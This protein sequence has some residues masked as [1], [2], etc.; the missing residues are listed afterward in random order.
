[1]KNA[2]KIC[3]SILL[4]IAMLSLAYAATP[5]PELIG[6][7]GGGFEIDSL[8]SGN[9]ILTTVECG[10]VR[11]S[12]DGGDTWND[13]SKGIPVLG[14]EIQNLWKDPF[15]DNTIFIGKASSIL[16]STDNGDTWVVVKSISGRPFADF[17]AKDSMHYFAVEGQRRNMFGDPVPD[18][19]SGSR[20]RIWKSSDGGITWIEGAQVSLNSTDELPSIYIHPTTKELY[21]A[22]AS[23]GVRKS[24]NDGATWENYSE[25]LS[26]L[27][28]HRLVADPTNPNIMYLTLG[29]SGSNPS[30][31]Y[32]RDITLGNWENITYNLPS[33][34]DL[35]DMAV[36]SNGVLY[37]ANFEPLNGDGGVYRFEGN[38]WTHLTR[39]TENMEQGWVGEADWARKPTGAAITIDPNND[40][41]IHFTTPLRDQ[42]F[43]TINGGENWSQI[44]A[45]KNPD[46]TWSNR[47]MALVGTHT[48][49]VDPSNS[50]H[51]ILGYGDYGDAYSE[52]GGLTWRRIMSTAGGDVNKILFD[53]A[54]SSNVWHVA[55]YRGVP[56]SKFGIYYSNDSGK[57]MVIVGGTNWSF[58]NLPGGYIYDIALDLSSPVNNRIVYIVAEGKGVYKGQGITQKI[59]TDK[60]VK[61]DGPGL[62]VSSAA[63]WPLRTVAYDS[64]RGIL[65]VGFEIKGTGTGGVYKTTNGGIS[66]EEVTGLNGSGKP[67]R[68]SIFRGMYV[69]PNT[70]DLYVGT[71]NPKG[72]AYRLQYLSSSWDNL[73]NDSKIQGLFLLPG[74]TRDKDVVFISGETN[75]QLAKWDK[76]GLTNLM[77][78]LPEKVFP[79]GLGVTYDSATDTLYTGR[80][81]AGVYKIEDVNPESPDTQNPT[82]SITSPNNGQTVSGIIN[83]QATASDNV[84]VTKVEFYIEGIIKSTDFSS[85]YEYSW[86]TTEVA[87]GNHSILVKAYDATNNTGTASILA[88]VQN[89]Y[90]PP[91]N[92]SQNR[93][94]SPIIITPIIVNGPN[95]TVRMQVEY[96]ESSV[97]KNFIFPKPAF[98]GM[99]NF[100]INESGTIKTPI[101]LGTELQWTADTSKTAFLLFEIPSPQTTLDEVVTDD[102]TTYQKEINI[103]TENSLEGVS[104]ST[105]VDVSY[106]Y[107]KLYEWQ[108][109]WGDVTT[110]YNLQIEDGI[111][112]FSGF[113]LSDKQFMLEGTVSSPTPPPPGGGSGDGGSGG[114]GGGV[115]IIPPENQTEETP[116]TDIGPNITIITEDGTP[117][118]IVSQDNKTFIVEGKNTKEFEEVKKS[119]KLLFYLLAVAGFIGIL[120]SLYA[121]RVIQRHRKQQQKLAMAPEVN[122]LVLEYIKNMRMRKYSDEVIKSELIKV[123]WNKEVVE[124]AFERI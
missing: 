34:A 103:S 9:R 91:T 60:W 43:K 14:G 71:G 76:N 58:N 111:A 1:M 41:I 105:S 56:A 104:V 83:I 106:T 93:F 94:H 52:D 21:V 29:A 113:D 16:R 69:N 19:T 100:R 72:G 73:A 64:V 75:T 92:Q 78:R 89:E 61:I 45:I 35:F 47:G 17:A 115:V 13:S 66:W 32:R 118:P 98:V 54:N 96:N 102:G 86:N 123:G 42:H 90:V 37:V 5:P 20:A 109:D 31:V 82:A 81:C 85:P 48:I 120:V 80:T 3:M 124:K 62:P 24:T 55:G 59:D 15:R 108:P 10:G 23:G 4:S 63:N 11:V 36:N 57:N 70:G 117:L 26:H 88:N 46:G 33:N 22:T 50:N 87:N 122:Y 116:T 18:R 67:A 7:G 49:A 84:A 28:S 77:N 40:N 30:K 112:T 8:F 65:Y 2:V 25:G 12:D 95:L 110:R 39:Y 99:S 53:P 101:D 79:R 68:K 114:G 121:T 74:L 6:L 107:W 38:R 27:T 119:N 97:I 51:I 44:Y